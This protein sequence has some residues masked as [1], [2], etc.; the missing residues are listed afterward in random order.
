MQFSRDTISHPFNTPQLLTISSKILREWPEIS[1]SHIVI[2]LIPS[3]GAG[4]PP[5]MLKSRIDVML[6]HLLAVIKGPIG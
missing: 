3:N 5:M 6:L 2:A 4:T 1:N